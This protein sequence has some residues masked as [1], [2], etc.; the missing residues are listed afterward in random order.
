MQLSAEGASEPEAAAEPAASSAAPAATDAQPE[1]VFYEGSGSNAELAISLLLGATLLFLP[2]T[3]ASIGQR[4]WVSYKFTNKRL[5]VITSSPVLK[6]EVQVEYSKIKEIRSAP[7]A[8][9]LWGDVVF[10]LKDGSRLPLA[11]LERYQEIVD[12]VQGKLD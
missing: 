3:I 10:F 12:Y 7:R 1:T 11:G 6:R 8:F 5:V 2:L 9:G 4:L